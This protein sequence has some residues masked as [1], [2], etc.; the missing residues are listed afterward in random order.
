M[1]RKVAVINQKG[2][3]GK[4]TTTANL[5]YML[6]Q[7]G[8]RVTLIDLDPQGSLT[9]SLGV[10]WQEHLGIEDLLL[11]DEKLENVIVESRK[12]LNLIPCGNHLG[13]IEHIDRDSSTIAKQLKRVL[14]GIDD[15]FILID[16]PPSSGFLIIC[17]L[18]SIDEVLIPVSSDYL[19][20]HGLSHLLG[21]LKGFEERLKHDIKKW[22]VITRF[23]P[24]RRLSQ[25]VKDKMIS[26]FSD[27]VLYTS[28]RET[29]A[30]AESPS[31]GLTVEEYQKNCKGADDYRDLANDFC[32]GRTC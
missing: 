29:T 27:Q 7:Q 23:H 21:T 22:F 25:D 4:T 15:D 31:F 16:C 30:L 18:Y 32:I 2:G 17:A 6:A 12:N 19:T 13:Q 8:Y 24:R 10:D 9:I 20:L 1:T 14:N 28:V 11:H 3:V 5:G 26:Y